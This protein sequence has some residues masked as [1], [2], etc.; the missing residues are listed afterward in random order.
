MVLP[1]R[2]HQQKEHLSVDFY[3]IRCGPSDLAVFDAQAKSHTF[4]D[5]AGSRRQS[6]P[7]PYDEGRVQ[8]H[9]L[10]QT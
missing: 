8:E 3:A 7:E 2:A 4:D 6:A 5:H 9:V 10:I 1:T